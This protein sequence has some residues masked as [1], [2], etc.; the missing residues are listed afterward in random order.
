MKFVGVG[1]PSG[2]RGFGEGRFDPVPT[3]DVSWV[4]A[5]LWDLQVA[6]A[7]MVI[8][9]ER[10]LPIWIVL[11]AEV[12]RPAGAF[13]LAGEHIL[14]DGRREN[15]RPAHLQNLRVRAFR[16]VE[17]LGV[18]ILVVDDSDRTHTVSEAKQDGE[19]DGAAD[20]QTSQNASAVHDVPL[21]FKGFHQCQN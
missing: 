14:H 6:H 8:Y 16:A 7:P 20:S 9:D 18:S 21:H 13:Y 11:I 19:K 12:P 1:G 15:E 4:P 3:S 10:R 2:L 5:L 17:C